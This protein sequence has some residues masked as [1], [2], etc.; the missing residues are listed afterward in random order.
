MAASLTRAHDQTLPDKVQARPA[1][2]TRIVHADSPE[3]QAHSVHL[4]APSPEPLI[5]V[6]PSAILGLIKQAMTDVGLKQEAAAA[7]AG[8]KPSQFSSALNGQGN[9]GATWLYAQDDRFILRLVELVME[10]RQ[11]TPENV[12]AIRR[13]RI[14]E[15]LDLLLEEVA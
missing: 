2:A 10:T 3:V 11:L 6:K 1:K 5:D 7:I 8:V 12:S 15:L 14:V 4:H 13:R 9:F